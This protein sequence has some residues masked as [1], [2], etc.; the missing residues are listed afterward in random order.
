ML[1]SELASGSARTLKYLIV[2]A[3]RVSSLQDV[4]AFAIAYWASHLI[5]SDGEHIRLMMRRT[6]SSLFKRKL[7]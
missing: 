1:L 4:R 7:I 3:R 5:L 6:K 2:K